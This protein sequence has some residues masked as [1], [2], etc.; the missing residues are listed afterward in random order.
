MDRELKTFKFEVKEV[1]EE[2]GTFTG[3]AATFSKTPD[4]YG[5]IIDPGA[6]KKTLKAQKGQIVC[7]FNHSIMEPIGKPTEMAEDEKGL[8]IKAKLSLGVQRA[9]EVLSLMKDGVIT[10]MSIGYNTMKE[11]WDEGVRHL[12]ELKL[13][14]CSPVVFAANTEAVI[15]GVKEMELKPYPSEHACRLLDPKDFEDGSFRRM[16]RV[17]DGKK[18]SVI[19]GRL[20]GEDTL[21][22]Q[23]YRYDKDVWDADDAKTHCKDHDGTFEAAAKKDLAYA[24]QAEMVLAAVTEWIDRTKSLA[25]LRLKEGRV[26]STANRKRLASLLEALG[27]MAKDIKELLE[28]TE[29]GPEDD[30]KMQSLALIVS[31]MKAANEGF[32]VREAEGHIESILEQLQK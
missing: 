7:L 9:R 19:M 24:D 2:E 15:I 10:Q 5:D 25:D 18:Y 12:Q 8:L 1:D 16:T 11:T 14:D 6:F 29:P 17:S 3:Y 26:L 20:E 23:A 22:E 28:A 27:T 13:Y 30:E 32:D 21:T 4:S 31:G